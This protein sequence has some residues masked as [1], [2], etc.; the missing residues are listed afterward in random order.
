M[1]GKVKKLLKV[2]GIILLFLISITVL[3]SII[4]CNPQLLFKYKVVNENLTLYSDEPIPMNA[5]N[6]LE[7]VQAK[8]SKSEVYKPE[9]SY[10]IFVCNEMNKFK[11][12][13]LSRNKEIG[14]FCKPYLSSNVFISKSNIESNRIL[15]SYGYEIQGART[16]AYV[17][18]HEL[19]HVILKGKAGTIAALQLPAWINE[20]YSEYIAQKDFN[21]DKTLDLLKSGK[22]AEGP[23][24]MA[25]Y[26]DKYHLLMSYLLDRKKVSIEEIL[27]G[28]FKSFEV[29]KELL[30]TR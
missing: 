2:I 1:T 4:F 11:L 23:V 5:M 14:G 21:Y 3:Y 9:I 10:K 18:A 26:Y 25:Y 17:I 24:F 15:S 27:S 12:F 7:E 8:L 30:N 28:K 16:L 22:L 6:I 29:E 19:T 13:S 20:G